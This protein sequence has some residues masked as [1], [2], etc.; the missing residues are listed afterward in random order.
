MTVPRPY[1][2]S[3]YAVFWLFVF[4]LASGDVT[5]IKAQ[6]TF[7]PVPSLG[8]GQLAVGVAYSPYRRKIRGD[9]GGV[10]NLLDYSRDTVFL[11]YGLSDQSDLHFEL[12]V[13]DLDNY[14]GF[15]L[16]AGYY[17]D[18][19]LGS[20]VGKRPLEAGYFGV[21]RRSEMSKGSSSSEMFQ[22]DA[23]GGAALFFDPRFAVYASGLV[24]Y[25]IGDVDGAGFGAEELIGVSF[26]A[27]YDHDKKFRFGGEMHLLYESG[28]SL[29]GRM[30]F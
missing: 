16:G 29:Y 12:S 6:T 22:L 3:V 1:R 26:G 7:S 9:G 13:A 19:G 2:L 10:S 21:L 30:T 24:S 8:K 25:L 28:L 18:L 15:E 17:G 11:D 23:G 20:R 14:R 4:L 27:F 5:L